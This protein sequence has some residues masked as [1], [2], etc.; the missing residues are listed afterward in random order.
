MDKQNTA[1]VIDYDF[2]D[3]SLNSVSPS[4]GNDNSLIK[5][6]DA[7]ELN[8][9]ACTVTNPRRYCNDCRYSRLHFYLVFHNSIKKWEA[10]FE[11]PKVVKRKFPQANVFYHLKL[12]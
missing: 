10:A 3:S 12:G 7:V 8:S 11:M 1:A 6:R 4:S 2:Y 9:L 5:R